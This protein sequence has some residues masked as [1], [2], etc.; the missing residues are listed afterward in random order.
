MCD[1]CGWEQVCDEIEDMLDEERFEYAAAT[2]NGIQNTIGGNE[3]VTDRQKSAVENI[4]RGGES[5]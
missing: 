1:D 2:L 4:R 3:H 5:R